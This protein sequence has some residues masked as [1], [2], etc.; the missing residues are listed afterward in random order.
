MKHLFCVH[1]YPEGKHLKIPMFDTPII[2][3]IQCSSAILFVKGRLLYSGLSE[4]M[5]DSFLHISSHE[6]F[7]FNILFHFKTMQVG[8][9]LHVLA[10]PEADKLLAIHKNLGG[11]YCGIELP[12]IIRRTMTH[13]F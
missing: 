12:I 10:R 11:N 3:N 4:G 13:I 2:F 7:F 5:C 1:I 6:A 8:I 9:S